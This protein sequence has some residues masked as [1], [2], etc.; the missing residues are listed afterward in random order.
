MSNIL[1][2]PGLSD[3]KYESL[4]TKIAVCSDDR[5][6]NH[7]LTLV[8]GRVE[9]RFMLWAGRL[10]FPFTVT[11]NQFKVLVHTNEYLIQQLLLGFFLQNTQ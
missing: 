5:D 10:G 11:I 6:V 3:W 7:G 8:E 9:E 2:L 1:R 4:N